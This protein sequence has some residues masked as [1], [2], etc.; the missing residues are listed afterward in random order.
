MGEGVIT[1][2]P[3]KCIPEPP[4]SRVTSYS[5][6]IHCFMLLPYSAALHQ[7]SF[8][9]WLLLFFLMCSISV[10]SG[11]LDNLKFKMLYLLLLYYYANG[12]WSWRGHRNIWQFFSLSPSQV[13]PCVSVT[14]RPSSLSGRAYLSWLWLKPSINQNNFYAKENVSAFFPSCAWQAPLI[15][16]GQEVGCVCLCV[17]RGGYFSELVSLFGSVLS[18]KIRSQI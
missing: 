12:L 14:H 10:S 15:S 17:G 3:L 18:I 6:S 9:G 13:H 8:S 1:V 16:Q 4:L 2:A 7:S 5:C 11:N